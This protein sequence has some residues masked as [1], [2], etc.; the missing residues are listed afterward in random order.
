MSCMLLSWSLKKNQ[1][2]DLLKRRTIT[3]I[4]VLHPTSN[5]GFRVYGLASFS[6]LN[7]PL[8]LPS[9]F[10]V[11]SCLALLS[12]SEDFEQLGGPLPSCLVRN[13]ALPSPSDSTRA[14]LIALLT[15]G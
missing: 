13:R 15:V 1:A 10:C 11:E 2:L 8:P 12:Y 14:R 3:F 5:E 9:E 4:L 6:A 7:W